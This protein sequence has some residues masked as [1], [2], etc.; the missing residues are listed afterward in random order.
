[1]KK[2]FHQTMLGE[3]IFQVDIPVADISIDKKEI[4]YAVGYIDGMLPQHF[5]GMIDQVISRTPE[6]CNIQ[7]GFRLLNVDRGSE[8]KKSI[9]V[10]GI[11]FQT[12]Q[13]VASQLK[14]ADQI[15]L[16]LCSL[17]SGMEQWSKQS[18]GEGDPTMG[19]FVDTVAS[20]VVETATDVLHDHV[21]RYLKTLGLLGTNRYSPGYCD[22]PVEEQHKLF[23]FFPIGFCGV[24]LTESALMI[25][26]KSVS[27]IIGVGEKVEFHPY[28][29]DDCGRKDCTYK[30][31][32]EKKSK[33]HSKRN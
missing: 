2:L 9:Q 24:S 32:R 20:V 28:F 11:H 19:Y 33:K 31:F 3:N 25:P 7:A 16:F 27:G 29:C 4:A 23:S 8:D 12:R 17:G 22:W 10:S 21:N 30:A 26:I 13:I 5:D 6:L 18:I 15:I 1:M 14:H